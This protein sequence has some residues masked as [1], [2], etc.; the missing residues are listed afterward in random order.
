MSKNWKID[1]KLKIDKENLNIFWTTWGIS[2]TFL[3][4]MWLMIILK[5]IKKKDFNLPVENTFVKKTQK[6]VKFTPSQFI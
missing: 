5:V 3:G 2:M 4:K 6:G 1:E